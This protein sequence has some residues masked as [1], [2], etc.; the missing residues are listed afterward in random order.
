MVGIWRRH[1]GTRIGYGIDWMAQT[2][3]GQADT[4]AL[5]APLQSLR[6]P[7]RDSLAARLGFLK[8]I[9]IIFFPAY[10]H[11]DGEKKL[12]PKPRSHAMSNTL[13][14]NDG[15]VMERL[16]L[17]RS[18]LQPPLDPTNPAILSPQT[19]MVNVDVVK[20]RYLRHRGEYLLGVD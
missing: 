12:F 17:P 18:P 14:R 3:L 1:S 9:D 13:T 15:P 4:D 8:S 2:T 7:Q 20:T 6:Y 19:W 5:S 11:Q 16:D 10:T